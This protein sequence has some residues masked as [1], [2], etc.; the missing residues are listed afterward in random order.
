MAKNSGTYIFGTGV[1]EYPVQCLSDSHQALSIRLHMARHMTTGC[2]GRCQLCDWAAFLAIVM[3]DYFANQIIPERKLCGRICGRADHDSHTPA[4]G[5]P[6]QSI[7][8]HDI[9]AMLE[10]ILR[11]GSI[12]DG[13]N[14]FVVN[15]ISRF[16]CAICL[17]LFP[18]GVRSFHLA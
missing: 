14:F 13:S 3:P 6:F 4:Y 5:M 17:R 8:E 18:S 1:A 11:A 2:I 16:T 10:E 15:T 9:Q 12:K 7:R